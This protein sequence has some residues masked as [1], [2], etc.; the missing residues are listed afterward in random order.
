MKLRYTKKKERKW[1][2]EARQQSA[3]WKIWDKKCKSNRGRQSI[4]NLKKE[5]NR[6]ITKQNLSIYSHKFILKYGDW[7]CKKGRE[8]KNSL[9]MWIFK[10]VADDFFYSMFA[11]RMSLFFVCTRKSGD[12][13][14]AYLI[15]HREAMWFLC[16]FSRQPSNICG[17]IIWCSIHLCWFW[18]VAFF[19]LFNISTINM[20]ASSR[21]NIRSEKHMCRLLISCLVIFIRHLVWITGNAH[22]ARGMRLWQRLT[23]I[24]T[25][26]SWPLSLFPSLSLSLQAKR[27]QFLQ[28]NKRITSQTNKR[29]LA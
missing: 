26:N 27:R 11:P 13:Q 1:A 2:F 15:H 9:G 25:P 4:A 12:E 7:G 29:R 23:Q 17:I 18:L 28:L 10:S 24:S 21:S 6:N 20:S 8:R 14:W 22:K 3:E 19:I 16:F 5:T